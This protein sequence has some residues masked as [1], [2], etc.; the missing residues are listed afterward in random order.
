MSISKTMS[1]RIA[2][3]KKYYETHSLKQ[4]AVLA[5]K[6]ITKI[7]NDSSHESSSEEETEEQQ[8]E[9]MEKGRT[10]FSTSEEKSIRA[11]FGSAIQGAKPPFLQK[12]REYLDKNPQH[13]GC[14]AKNI[15]DKLRH[16]IRRM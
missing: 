6:I 15:Q 16:L 12:C 7:Q 1:H 2:T 11:W 5:S 8:E 4:S 10:P 9:P 13:G 3:H 14:T